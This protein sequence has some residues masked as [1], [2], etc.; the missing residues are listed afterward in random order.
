MKWGK[1]SGCLVGI[2]FALGFVEQAHATLDGAE[3]W[4]DGLCRINGCTTPDPDC[5]LP[6]LPRL[7][8]IEP[9][10]YTTATLS[11]ADVDDILESASNTLQT[12]NGSGDVSC[13]V[14]F[15]RD[16]SVTTFS[17]GDGSVDSQAEFDALI[18][19]AG[20]AK[21][22]NQINWCG[23]IAFGI[24]GC[25][26]VP[27]SSFVAVRGSTT[28]Q[29]GIIWAHEHGHTQGLPHRTGDVVMKSSLAGRN[30]RVNSTECNAYRN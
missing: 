22:V 8:N 15:Q 25:A 19:L 29:E 20:D 27:G 18:A 9:R 7:I 6:P 10:R 26:P 4:D 11:N 14:I 17:T 5:D 3:C 16:G 30:T 13:D 23:V 24:V 1:L 2:M 21:V 12:N 28:H